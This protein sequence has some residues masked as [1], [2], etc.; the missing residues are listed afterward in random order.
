MSD[1][2]SNQSI[3]LSHQMLGLCQQLV[4]LQMDDR[5][6]KYLRSGVEKNQISPLLIALDDCKLAQSRNPCEATATFLDAIS[7]FGEWEE[8]EL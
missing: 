6:R 4:L 7:L 3:P 8:K 2:T 5:V 1:E